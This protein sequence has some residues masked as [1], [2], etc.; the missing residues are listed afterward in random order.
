MNTF[1]TYRKNGLKRE[2]WDG[3]KGTEQIKE[4]KKGSMYGSTAFVDLG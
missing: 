2:S 1:M 4:R 3:D